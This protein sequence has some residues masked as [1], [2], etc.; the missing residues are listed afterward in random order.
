M[1]AKLSMSSAKIYQFTARKR[2]G[3]VARTGG[4]QVVAL[5]P[6]LAPVIQWGAS[7]HDDAIAEAARASWG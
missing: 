6:A 1:I 4:A 2:E 7:Y 3:S 5:R